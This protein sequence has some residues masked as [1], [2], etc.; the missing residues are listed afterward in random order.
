MILHNG[1]IYT[2]SQAASLAKPGDT[3]LIDPGTYSEEV[4]LT[5]SG[6]PTA[7]ITFEAQT[8]GT[9]IINAAN[10]AQAISSNFANTRYINLDGLTVQG[11][12]NADPSLQAAITTA[13]RR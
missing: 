13:T 11:C 8:P 7:P 9:V 5:T 12:N 2:I 1:P 10:F 3:V 6:T 4:F